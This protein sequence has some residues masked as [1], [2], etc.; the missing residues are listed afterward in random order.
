MCSSAAEQSAGNS[1]QV[2]LVLTEAQLREIVE[3]AIEGW[4]LDV[5]QAVYIR[6]KPY[7][8]KDRRPGQEVGA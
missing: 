7:V 4:G 2:R 3:A 8:R 1:P 5:T 6:L